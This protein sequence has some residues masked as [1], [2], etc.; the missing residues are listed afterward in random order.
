M[1]DCMNP[2]RP[3]ISVNAVVGV[4]ALLAL[5][6]APTRAEDVNLAETG[7][8]LI[9]PL[10]NVWVSEYAKTHPGIH[11][12]TGSTGSGAGIEQEIGRAHV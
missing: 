3:R 12:T 5:Q 1:T 9:Y 4:L 11:I 2:A 6:S 8:T 7:S 10:F